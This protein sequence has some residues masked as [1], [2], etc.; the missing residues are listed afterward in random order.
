MKLLVTGGAG[1]IGS[2]FVAQRVHAG[3]EVIVLDLLTYAGHLEN[4][5]PV[6]DDHRFVQGDVCDKERVGQLV[7][8]DLDAVVNFAAES[9]V[10][11]SILDSGDFVRTNVL[12]VQVLLDAVQRAGCGRL[13]QVSTDEV[14]GPIAPRQTAT[15]R[16]NL[17]PSSPYA[18]SKAAA[19]LL[20]LAFRQTHGTPVM[21]TRCTNNYGPYQYPEKLIPLFLLRAMAGEELPLYGDG[22]HERDWLHVEDH[23][24]ALAAVLEGGKD[25]EVYNI[26]Y[27]EPVPNRLV[28]EALLH[29]LDLPDTPIRSVEDRPGH[30]RRYAV[31]SRKIRDGLGWQPTIPLGTGL[32]RTVAWYRDNRAWLEAVTGPEFD[33]YCAALYGDRKDA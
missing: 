28:V 32:T 19:D 25:G 31:A 9:H 7:T 30:D 15:E 10:D 29:E 14:Y 18:S 17:A 16:S 8:A 20:C 6:R 3:D 27:G 12:G 1:F 23:C 13:L 11:R 33:Q 4:L 5:A 2:N 21:I 26:A 24:R 22:L